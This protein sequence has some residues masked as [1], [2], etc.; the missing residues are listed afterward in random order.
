MLECKSYT[1]VKMVFRFIKAFISRE[2]GYLDE[3]KLITVCKINS[4]LFNFLEFKSCI[5][6]GSK[7]S[8]YN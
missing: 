4:D 1:A 7:M 6:N 8:I 3:P 2:V 5:V